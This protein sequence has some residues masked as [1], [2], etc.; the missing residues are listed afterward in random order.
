MSV[1]PESATLP[2]AMVAGLT[3]PTDGVPAV[4]DGTVMVIASSDADVA[5]M[6]LKV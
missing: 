4:P 3:V 5:A 6:K 1:V 2:P